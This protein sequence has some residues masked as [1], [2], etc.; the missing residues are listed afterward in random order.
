MGYTQGM[1]FVLGF[2]LL[3][4]GDEYKAFQMFNTLS[5]KYQL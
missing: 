1:N 5:D 4:S 2:I 3:I